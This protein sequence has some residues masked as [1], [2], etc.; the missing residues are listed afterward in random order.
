MPNLP[1]ETVVA[2]YRLLVEESGGKAVSQTV[3]ER[4]SKISACYWRGGYWRS[5][6]EFQA[7][8]GFEPNG[9][10]E[11]IPDEV[12]RRFAEL[13]LEM[14]KAPTQAGLK[15]RRKED[16]TLPDR[17]VFSR[18]RRRDKPAPFDESCDMVGLP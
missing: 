11:K 7:E 13:A 8:L 15:L 10:T 4:E 18:L 12:L 16:P 2:A 9:R 3:F 6:S 1:K 17:G 14:K 5:W